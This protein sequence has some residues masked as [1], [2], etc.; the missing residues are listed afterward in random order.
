[1]LLTNKQVF[2]VETLSVSEFAT[3]YGNGITS[4]AV[5]Y[6]MDNDLV[7]YVTLGDRR[8][9]V[10]TKRTKQYKPNDSPSRLA[11]RRRSKTN[12]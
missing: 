9:V 10:M 7:D 8:Y 6:A 11:V 3:K 12:A 1:M 2:K 4:H 5:Y